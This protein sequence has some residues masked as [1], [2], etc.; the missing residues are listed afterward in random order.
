MI[1]FKNL[2]IS[3]MIMV[4]IGIVFVLGATLNIILVQYSM[5]HQSLREAEAKARKRSG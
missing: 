2:K 3:H 5:R 4:S 1:K